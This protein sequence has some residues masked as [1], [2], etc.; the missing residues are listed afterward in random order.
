MKVGLIQTRG[1]GDLVIALPIANWYLQQGHSVSWPVDSRFVD[2]M[3]EA[4]DRID[5][6]PV[7]HNSVGDNSL[8]FFHGY[9]LKA[10]K[11]R[12]C[13]RI[14]TLYSYLTNVAIDNPRLANSLK[15]DEYKYAV[16]GVP[17]TEKWNLQVKRNLERE[18]A[19]FESLRIER[20]Y[21]C[22]HRT[23][24]N[25]E[26][27][28]AIPDDWKRDFQIVEMGPITPNPFDWILTLERAARLV[29][30]DSSFANLVEGLNIGGEKFLIVRSP[31]AFTP[32]F[33]NAWRM[34]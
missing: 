29:M 27:D 17:F 32:V 2:F 33:K 3:R 11:E 28:I 34:T 8:D 4:D 20:P 25:F 14:F 9:P 7:D 19:L 5:F 15:F 31:C 18:T 24:S 12:G 10:L 13:D 16:A 6:I 1:I 26:S 23:G 21:I 30:I 22:I